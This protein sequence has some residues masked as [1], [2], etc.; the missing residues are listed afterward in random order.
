MAALICRG[1]SLGFTL[2]PY[3]LETPIRHELLVHPSDD[4]MG[5][6]TH[7]KETG[8]RTFAYVEPSGVTEASDHWSLD[9]LSKFPYSEEDGSWIVYR[10]SPEHLSSKASTIL[11]NHCQ[12]L[13][14]YNWDTWSV[15]GKQSNVSVVTSWATY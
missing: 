12:S 14:I 9:I 7:N 3:F 11:S 15:V 4:V 1:K 2:L 8:K 13:H 6:V 10:C 5:Y